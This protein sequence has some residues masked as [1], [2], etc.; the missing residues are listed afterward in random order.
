MLQYLKNVIKWNK[1]KIIAIAICYTI[2]EINKNHSKSMES[3]QTLSNAE[4]QLKITKSLKSKQWCQ[5]YKIIWNV[6][7][8]L[9]IYENVIK[10]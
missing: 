1:I 8:S 4:N 2:I 9:K 7:K 6:V 3:V 5:I 10:S